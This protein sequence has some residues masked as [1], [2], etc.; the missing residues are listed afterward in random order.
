MLK[1]DEGTM[2]LYKCIKQHLSKNE[3][4]LRE[5][6][7]EPGEIDFLF[8][9]PGEDFIQIGT[10]RRAFVGDM[11]EQLNKAHGGDLM[12][13]YATQKTTPVDRSI[14]YRT[15]KIYIKQNI[16]KQF[17][18]YILSLFRKK[19]KSDNETFYLEDLYENK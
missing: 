6:M 14:V 3:V 17:H 2:G 11:Q 7:Y 15:E 16:F 4:T 19:I 1:R 18:E 5:Y 10:Y 9:D 8:K 13:Q 12:R